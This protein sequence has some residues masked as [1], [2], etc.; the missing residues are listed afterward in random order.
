MY[1][2]WGRQRADFAGDVSPDFQVLPAFATPPI[3]GQPTGNPTDTELVLRQLARIFLVHDL[4][5]LGPSQARDIFDPV[6]PWPASVPDR[7]E[8]G[9]SLGRQIRLH[10]LK[11]LAVPAGLSMDEY[12]AVARR[13]AEKDGPKVPGLYLNTYKWAGLRALEAAVAWRKGAQARAEEEE[14]AGKARSEERAE[15]SE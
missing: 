15:E 12:G 3:P 13:M 1:T 11:V 7:D 8:E 5:I 6:R 10:G 14:A 2:Q 4:S 9:S